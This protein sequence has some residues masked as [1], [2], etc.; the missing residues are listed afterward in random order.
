MDN[1][2]IQCKVCIYQYEDTL[3]GKQ[4][5]SYDIDALGKHVDMMDCV[6]QFINLLAERCDVN[7]GV[8]MAKIMEKAAIFQVYEK[9]GHGTRIQKRAT[10]FDSRLLKEIERMIKEGEKDAEK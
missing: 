3:N 10:S 8:I 5:I 6:A 2:K 1:K 4:G 9:T 7:V